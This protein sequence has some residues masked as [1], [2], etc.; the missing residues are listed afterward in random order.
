M[1]FNWC[2]KNVFEIM[3][4]EDFQYYSPEAIFQ[5]ESESTGMIGANNIELA[6]SFYLARYKEDGE[7]CN[8][9]RAERFDRNAGAAQLYKKCGIETFSTPAREVKR[10]KF[11][12]YGNKQFKGYT[13]ENASSYGHS[14]R[15]LMWEIL[16]Y[17]LSNDRDAD[18]PPAPNKLSESSNEYLH[19]YEVLKGL[20]EKAA[21]Y[22]KYLE[23]KGII[24]KMWSERPSCKEVVGDGDVCFEFIKNILPKGSQF[25]FIVKDYERTDNNPPTKIEEASR[26]LK[27][28]YLKFKQAQ[29]NE[30]PEEAKRG[31][32]ISD[33]EPECKK[34][35]T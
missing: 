16:D 21:D 3:N 10:F 33:S 29:K 12:S 26:G 7:H 2:Q 1:D 28:A 31:S 20:T 34:R 27:N 5:S 11:V 19:E 9:P 23:K 24:V 25:G 13:V 18:D 17:L 4:N 32:T 8:E 22:K 15:V 35:C 30:Q 14:E 6:T